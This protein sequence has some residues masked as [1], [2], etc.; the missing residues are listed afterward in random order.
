MRL[1]SENSK[2]SLVDKRSASETFARSVH[3]LCDRIHAKKIQRLRMKPASEGTPRLERLLA[4]GLQRNC[5]LMEVER[6][7]LKSKSPAFMQV[8]ELLSRTMSDSAERLP[9]F[10]DAIRVILNRWLHKR[11]LNY[12]ERVWLPLPACL[13]SAEQYDLEHEHCLQQC[14]GQTPPQDSGLLQSTWLG[15]W[16]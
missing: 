13:E 12:L 11:Q 14:V 10:E 4:R 7:S 3:N 2:Y 6:S 16:D 8:K 9:F 1:I 15:R 5:S